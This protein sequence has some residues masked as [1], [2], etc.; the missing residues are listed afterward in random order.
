MRIELL[1]RQLQS[2]GRR[3]SASTLKGE[4]FGLFTFRSWFSSCNALMAVFL[5]RSNTAISISNLRDG[6]SRAG[7]PA[8]TS[9]FSKCALKHNLHQLQ[10]LEGSTEFRS[11]HQTPQNVASRQEPL[12]KLMQAAT[13][14]HL[15]PLSISL[16]RY[17]QQCGRIR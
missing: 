3:I 1:C 6:I 9:A 16:G 11:R 14:H 7:L 17:H 5:K 13:L 2:C 15:K 4:N 10:Q 12:H 8:M